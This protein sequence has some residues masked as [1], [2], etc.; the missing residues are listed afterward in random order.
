MLHWQSVTRARAN[1]P[2][3][4]LWL[5]C[6]ACY[7][8]WSASL[9]LWSSRVHPCIDPQQDAP[10]TEEVQRVRPKRSRYV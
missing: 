5:V 1:H 6:L 9:S 10:G 4:H 2:C 7:P 3:T 8:F